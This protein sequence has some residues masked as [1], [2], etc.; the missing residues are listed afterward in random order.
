MRLPHDLMRTLSDQKTPRN[1]A[2]A[3][4]GQ[5]PV[6]VIMRGQSVGTDNIVKL[7]LGNERVHRLDPQVPEGLFAL[8]KCTRDKHMAL[9]ARESLHFG[10]V[11]AQEFK[12]H[13]ASTYTPLYPELD[14]QNSTT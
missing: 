5:L 12:P 6:D 10:P 2:H 8:D 3:Q 4:N 13:I 9:A 1:A 7:L 14:T 11:F